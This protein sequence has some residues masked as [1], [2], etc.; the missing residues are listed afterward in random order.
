[1]S[2][3]IGGSLIC[4]KDN[5]ATREEIGMTKVAAGIT[6]SVDGYITGPNDG[7]ERGLGEGGERLHYWV[8]GGPWTYA[9]PGR[10]EPTGADKEYLD[11]EMANMGAVVG[12]RGTFESAAAWGGTNPWPVPFFVVTHR[13]QDEPTDAGFTFVDGLETAISRARSAAGDK[14]VHLMGGAD[15][16]RQALRAGYLDELS[17]S[18]AP[19]VLGAGKRLFNGFDKSVDLELIR[20]FSSPL[21]THIRYR[22]VR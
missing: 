7:P 16:I 10:G 9:K 6:T 4:E 8:F 15:V 22:V 17:V 3:G 5:M 21:A 18:I 1:M 2:F 12:G 13:P 20:T 14:D 11:G 19:V